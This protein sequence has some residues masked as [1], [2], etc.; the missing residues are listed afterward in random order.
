[1][2]VIFERMAAFLAE[3]RVGLGDLGRFTEVRWDKKDRG[4]RGTFCLHFSI[5]GV[6]LAREP[7]G[8]REGRKTGKRSHEESHIDTREGRGWEDASLPDIEKRPRSYCGHAQT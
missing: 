4:G 3:E 5:H 7:G 8:G 1:M 2:R 6:V